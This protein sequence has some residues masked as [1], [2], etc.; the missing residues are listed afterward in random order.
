MGSWADADADAEATSC[1]LV[2]GTWLQMKTSGSEY[3]CVR[4]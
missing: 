2:K 4:A 3:A 1:Y